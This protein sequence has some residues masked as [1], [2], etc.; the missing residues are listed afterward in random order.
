[1]VVQRF[2]QQYCTGKRQNGRSQTS[3][4]K[5]LPWILHDDQSPLLTSSRV[6]HTRNVLRLQYRNT[7]IID[8]TFDTRLAQATTR[9]LPVGPDGAVTMMLIVA[10]PK[11]KMGWNTRLACSMFKLQAPAMSPVSKQA[12]LLAFTSSLNCCSM[13][14]EELATLAVYHVYR[15]S[16]CY[17]VGCGQA[18][19]SVDTHHWRY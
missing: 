12:T 7:V 14:A 8:L 13:L 6:L 15:L 3:I 16:Q 10:N 2:V 19:V 1:M 5:P 17:I 4:I 11:T 18:R 9:P